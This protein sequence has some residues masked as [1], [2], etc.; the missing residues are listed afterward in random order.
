MKLWCKG[1][2]FPKKL[3]GVTD[4]WSE[5]LSHTK[6]SIREVLH[7]WLEIITKMA[8]FDGIIAYGLSS[9]E[10]K[11]F[12]NIVDVWNKTHSIENQNKMLS[13]DYQEKHKITCQNISLLC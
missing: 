1:V 4:N 9:E 6:P 7:Q 10:S 3:K 11:I 5:R 8:Y 12:M 2:H 13:N